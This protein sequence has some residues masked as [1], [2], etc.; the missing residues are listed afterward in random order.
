M[1]YILDTCTLI[2][3]CSK[4]SALSRSARKVIDDSASELALSDVSVMEITMKWAAGKIR[5]PAS[6]RTW[7]ESQARTWRLEQFQIAREDIYRSAELPAHHRDPFD[8][9]LVGVTLNRNATL[10]T[11]DTAIREYPVSTCW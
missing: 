9:L 1:T 3:L 4:P 7:I 8:R 5:L 10:I 6:P 11:P 2:W